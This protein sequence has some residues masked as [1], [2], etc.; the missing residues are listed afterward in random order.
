MIEQ[1]KNPFIVGDWIKSDQDFIGRRDLIKK[2]LPLERQYNWLIGA[3]RMGKTSLLRYLQRQYQKQARLI[4]L[5]WDVSGANSTYDLKQSFIDS[6]ESAEFDFSRLNI[7]L[8]IE[9]IE[10]ESLLWIF[11]WLIREC[12][13]KSVRIILLVDESEALFQVAVQDEQFLHQFKAIMVNQPLLSVIL[14]SNHGLAS[15]DKLSTAHFLAPFLQSFSP[16]DYITPWDEEDAKILIERCTTNEA[17]QQKIFVFTGCLPFL[18]QMI[19]FYYFDRGNLQASIK[20]IRQNN[21]L[22]L[23]FR[24]DFQHFDQVDYQILTNL[25]KLEPADSAAIK[26]FLNSSANF[27]PKR[28]NTL[29]WLGFTKQRTDQKYEL[30]SKFL[31]DWVA[32]NIP[33]LPSIIPT[34]KDIINSSEKLQLC[35]EKS[36]IKIFKSK[37]GEIKETQEFINIIN[38]K[39]YK[40]TNYKDI[41]SLKQIGRQLFL[42]LFPTKETQELFFEFFSKENGGDL[43]FSTSKERQLQIPFEILHDGHVFIS[44]R[45]GLYR[46]ICNQQTKTNIHF[47]PGDTLNIFLIAS[48]TPPGIPFVDNEIIL[49]KSQF[50]KIARE[51][52]LS[53][54]ITTSLSHESDSSY[55]M[56]L[57]QTNHYHFV[58]YAGHSGADPATSTDNIFLWEKPGKSGRV[59]AIT[60]DEMFPKMVKPPLFFYLNGCNSAGVNNNTNR[61][62]SGFAMMLLNTGGQA[63]LGNSSVTDDRA[64]AEFAMDFYWNLFSCQLSYSKALQQTRLKWAAQARFQENGH[65]FWMLPALWQNF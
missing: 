11:R 17:E 19:C 6:L 39:N 28:L 61:V 10:E 45:K 56:N 58:H 26:T 59:R 35:F 15:Y 22:D 40:I 36:S 48:D 65:L 51:H 13:Q 34:E 55:I 41:Q 2:Y 14:A 31:R 62:S 29:T 18:V 24:D 42:D 4:P 16:P 52:G 53:L 20:T 21:M 44:L 8:N 47:P 3:R 50:Q 54:N 7:D 46:S 32:E 60:A 23:F 57:L 49:L 43:V 5:F 27:I 64:S 12:R 30:N 25:I 1:H 33:A 9:K 37:N 63:F 38:P